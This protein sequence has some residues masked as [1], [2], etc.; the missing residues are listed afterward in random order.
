LL[1]NGAQRQE[2]TVGDG[3]GSGSSKRLILGV[4]V[5]VAGLVALLSWALLHRSTSP[6][7]MAMA[8]RFEK[9]FGA[10]RMLVSSTERLDVRDGPETLIAADGDGGSRRVLHETYNYFSYPG[11]SADGAWIAAVTDNRVYFHQSSRDPVPE[12]RVWSNRVYWVAR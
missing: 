5:A 3:M 7:E 4:A 11:M 2:V 6:D 10:E 9:V 8:S 1:Y 12:A